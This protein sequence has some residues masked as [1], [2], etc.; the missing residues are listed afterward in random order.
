MA[1]AVYWL[2]Y[3]TRNFWVGLFL[4]DRE[5][6]ANVYSN[7]LSLLPLTI[8]GWEINSNVRD[9]VWRLGVAVANCDWYV[10]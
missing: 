8:V 5:Q 9:T 2:V 10:C 6:V 7:E 1:L 4:S 3:R